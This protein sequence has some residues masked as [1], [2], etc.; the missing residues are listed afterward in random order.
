MIALETAGVSI[1]FIMMPTTRTRAAVLDIADLERD[2]IRFLREVERR[3]PNFHLSQSAIPI[4]PDRNF[5]D[6]AH[7]NPDAAAVFTNSP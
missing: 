1:D 5:V 2:F 6:A 3:H 4:W 7:L